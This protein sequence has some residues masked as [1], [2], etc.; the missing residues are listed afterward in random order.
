MATINNIPINNNKDFDNDEVNYWSFSYL[1]DNIFNNLMNSNKYIIQAVTKFND[2]RRKS[3]VTLFVI[4][5]K[6]L[7]EDTRNDLKLYVKD[8]KSSV[9]VYQ[10]LD[11]LITEVIALIYNEAK[12]LILST[13][14][15][16][17]PVWVERAINDIRSTVSN[18]WR[19]V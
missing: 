18:K 12:S 8:C 4:D 2:F 16:M 1:I 15:H 9:E 3:P 14:K 10:K 7:K 5:I 6:D 13:V 19:F 11:G 17:D